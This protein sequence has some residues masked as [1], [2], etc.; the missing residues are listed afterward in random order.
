MI[1]SDGVFCWHRNTNFFYTTAPPF[2]FTLFTLLILFMSGTLL[3]NI[4]PGQL[5]GELAGTWACAVLLGLFITNSSFRAF[6]TVFP[7][8]IGGKKSPSTV[9][10]RISLKEGSLRRSLPNRVGWFGY[11]VRMQSSKAHWVRSW[12]PSTCAALASP[13]ES[14]RH[15]GKPLL[16]NPILSNHLLKSLK[17]F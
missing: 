1:I 8:L 14:K 12:S 3:G 15:T 9:P 2:M 11:C 16:S 7:K 6:S 17:P 5:F 10:G 4:L 13:W